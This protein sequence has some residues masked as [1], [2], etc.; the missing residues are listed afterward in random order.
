MINKHY[1]APELANIL[2]VSRTTI[3]K[4]IKNG[5]IKAEKVGRNYIIMDKDITSI[6][7]GTLTSQDKIFIRQSVDKIWHDY[8]KTLEMLGKD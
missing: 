3:F 2:G 1:T 4:R 8:G 6:L 7:G 5:Q